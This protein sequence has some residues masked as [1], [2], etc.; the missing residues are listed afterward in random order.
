VSGTVRYLRLAVL[1]LL[2]N[3]RYSYRLVANGLNKDER[4]LLEAFCR[5]SPRLEYFYYPSKGVIDHGTMLNILFGRETSPY[6]CMADSDIFAVGPFEEELEENL[7]D[8]DVFSSCLPLSMNPAFVLPGFSGRCLKTPGGLPLAPTFFSVYRTELFRKIMMETKVGFEVY[9]PQVYLPPCVDHFVLP[10][11]LRE[12]GRIDTGKLLHILA[13]RYGARFR[14]AELTGLI[15]IGGISSK[16]RSWHEKVKE[17]LLGILRRPYVVTDPYIR[18]EMR[19]RSRSRAKK[20]RPHA[21]NVALE[22]EHIR[23][24]AL[25]NPVSTYFVHFFRSLFEG[26]PEPLFDVS[27]EGLSQTIHRVSAFIRELYREEY[28]TRQESSGR[29][30]PHGEL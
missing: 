6:F 1:S 16:R 26:T 2:K 4:L 12:A 11:N 13:G 30:Q 8:C 5:C 10:D 15:H 23:T 20:N 22:A 29:T 25:R 19:R 21:E 3:S 28:Q 9:R 7:R 18:S 24:R 27:D 17:A 14:H